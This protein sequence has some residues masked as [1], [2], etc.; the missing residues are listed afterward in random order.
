MKCGYSKAKSKI[1]RVATLKIESWC[2]E[3]KGK[4]IGFYLDSLILNL[5]SSFSLLSLTPTFEAN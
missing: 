2:T 5:D 4:I 1:R 3:E